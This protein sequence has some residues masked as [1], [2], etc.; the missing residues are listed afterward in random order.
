[1]PTE[2]AL[3][4]RAL[5]DEILTVVDEQLDLLGFMINGRR[6]Q[7]L[8]A[9]PQRRAGDRDGVDRVRL[10]RTALRAP[11]LAHQSRRHTHDALA[12]RDQETLKRA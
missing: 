6:R 3:D 12:M 2:A 11:T 1:M 10:A 8:D 9:L 7:G 4:A 5:P